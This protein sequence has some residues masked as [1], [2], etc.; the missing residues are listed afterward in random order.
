MKK[1]LIT[2]A[3]ALGLTQ[4]TQAQQLAAPYFCCDSIT[5]WTDQ[6][7]GLFVGL[8]TTNIIHN[9]DS[10]DVTWSVCDANVCYTETGM[11]A[12]FGQIVTTDTIKVCYEAW[13]YE[14]NAMEICTQCDSL[15]YNQNL[16]NWVPLSMSFQPSSI[17]ELTFNKVDDN[18]IY[19]MLGK[20]L[21]EAPIGQMY[22]Q[23]RK[24]YFRN[25]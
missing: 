12:F 7:Q 8:D 2:L 25:E 16:Y 24:L 18:K 13:I 9:P 5:Y 21:L 4:I 19:D 11:N 23:N 10:I 20:E 15:V 17:N 14:V 6:G 3:I 22:I 1:V